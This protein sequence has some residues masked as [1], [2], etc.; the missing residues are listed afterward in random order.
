MNEMY[1]KYAE[2][3]TQA[4]ENNI[5]NAGYDRPSMLSLIPDEVESILDMGCGSG[6]YLPSLLK[7]NKN[8]TAIDQ[9]EEFISI[10][11]DRFPD[12]RA[13]SHDLNF[14]IPEKEGQFD[15]VISPLTIHYIED[16]SRLFKD[17]LRLLKDGGNF[18]FSTHHPFLDF[19]SSNSGNYF[20]REYLTQEWNTLGSEKTKV[21]FYRRSLSE[22][23]NTL[24]G[25]GFTIDYL[26]EGIV[27][28]SVKDK[29][30]DVYNK[31]KTKPQFIF[32]RAKK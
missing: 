26:S 5:Y 12:I 20:E 18:I 32:I 16:W 2:D 29:N 8:I 4:I 9:S 31:L 30:K 10:V 27:D 17:V 13:Y 11:K 14:P 19:K 15:L 7:Y 3:Y 23:I 25:S 28:E 24:I 22:I 1:S 6:A 21:S